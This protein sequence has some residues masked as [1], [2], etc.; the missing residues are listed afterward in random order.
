LRP[1]PINDAHKAFAQAVVAL[2][3][4][5]GVTMVRGDFHGGHGAFR[6]ATPRPLD[7]NCTQI[8]FTWVRGRHG[9]KSRISLTASAHDQV[10]ERLPE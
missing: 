7:E 3:R 6:G 1:T 9:D 10:D 4:E 5:H 2:A 8:A